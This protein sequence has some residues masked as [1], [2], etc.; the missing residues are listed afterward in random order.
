MN[1]MPLYVKRF[2]CFCLVSIIPLAGC[3]P[4]EIESDYFQKGFDY[5][6]LGYTTL[7]ESASLNETMMIKNLRI[8][9]VGRAGVHP[10]RTISGNPDD[11]ATAM[12]PIHEIRVIGKKLKGKIIL[13]QVVLGN[14]LKHLMNA[15]NPEVICPCEME[16]FEACVAIHPSDQCAKKGP[17]H[18]R[19]E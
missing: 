2:L 5:S 1:Y 18:Q 8:V 15:L 10:S 19:Q 13:N 4:V 6:N 11:I 14:E 9:I 17:Q 7:P 12:E 16:A 3:A